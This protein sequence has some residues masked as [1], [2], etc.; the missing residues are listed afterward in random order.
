MYS[1]SFKYVKIFM[2]INKKYFLDLPPKNEATALGLHYVC[3]WCVRACA[4]I[5][6]ELSLIVPFLTEES[7]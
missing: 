7:L 1:L 3:L 4:V 2:M 5:L 6:E